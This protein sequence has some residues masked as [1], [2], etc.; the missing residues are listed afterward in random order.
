MT[1]LL[2]GLIVRKVSLQKAEAMQSI[3]GFGEFRGKVAGIKGRALL[4][5]GKSQPR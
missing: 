4:R 3:A 5:D 2:S 1:N